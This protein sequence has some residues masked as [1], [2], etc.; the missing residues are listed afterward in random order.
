MA[1]PNPKELQENSLNRLS[2]TS[3][4]YATQFIRFI[5][6]RFSQV[7]THFVGTA[8]P[9]LFCLGSLHLHSVPVTFLRY[10]SELF[11]G[12]IDITRLQYTITWVPASYLHRINFF[13]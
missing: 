3:L 9:E 2:S 6:L 7:I 1:P 13:S 12:S 8:P 4:H 10:W 11:R 5:S